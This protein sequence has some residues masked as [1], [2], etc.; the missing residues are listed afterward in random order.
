MTDT[1]KPDLGASMASKADEI[2]DIAR[3]IVERHGLTGDMAKAAKFTIL[4]QAL[5][6]MIVENANGSMD[7]VLTHVR[8]AASTVADSASIAFVAANPDAF[9]QPEA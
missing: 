2:A 4:A 5:G 6:A 1:A 8:L 3:S 7:D 9:K